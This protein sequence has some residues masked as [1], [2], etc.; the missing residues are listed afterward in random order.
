MDSTA[1]IYVCN[2]LKLIIDFSKQLIKV[3]G[4]ILNTVLSSQDTG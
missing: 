2:N 3:G 1:S 4:L